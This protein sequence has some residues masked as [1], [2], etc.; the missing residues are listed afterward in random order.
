MVKRSEETVWRSS[1]V[2]CPPA[3]TRP[4][5]SVHL[6]LTAK[7]ALLLQPSIVQPCDLHIHLFVFFTKATRT[8]KNEQNEKKCRDRPLVQFLFEVCRIDLKEL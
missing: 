7:R 6:H 5:P 1:F 3:M 2:L 4:F 8:R